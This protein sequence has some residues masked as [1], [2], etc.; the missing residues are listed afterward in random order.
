MSKGFF[1]TGTDTG[2]GKT[3]VS[4]AIIRLLRSIG[5]AAAAMKPVETGCKSEGGSLLPEDA[6]F[7]KRIAGMDEAADIVAPYRYKSPLAPLAAAETDATPL[8]DLDVI[9]K[10]FEYLSGKYEAVVVE[11]AGGLMVPL[12]ERY[13]ML[14][15]AAEL[16]LPLIVVSRPGLGMINHS[17]LTIKCALNAGLD[18]GGLVINY[19]SLPENSLA[20]KTNPELVQRLSPVP[21]MGIFPYLA[22]IN[23]EAIDA[24]VQN[25]LDAEILKRNL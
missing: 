6:I 10:L 19:S 25:C 17:L 2:V 12:T 20:E 15:L 22:E 18:V 9:K 24:A 21:L 5:I 14:D 4:A 23:E 16:G 3:V 8:P 1:I 13:Y 7:L 11:G